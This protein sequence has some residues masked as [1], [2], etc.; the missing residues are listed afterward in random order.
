LMPDIIIYQENFSRLLPFQA[1]M[2][3]MIPFF[4]IS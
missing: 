1:F 3:L 2:D 4:I